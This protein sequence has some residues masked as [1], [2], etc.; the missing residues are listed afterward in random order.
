MLLLKGYYNISSVLFQETNEI[1]R[2]FRRLLSLKY[3][4][5]DDNLKDVCQF[6]I[7]AYSRVG[8]YRVI[9]DIWEEYSHSKA[10]NTKCVKF[11]EH[12]AIYIEIGEYAKAE[13]YLQR[14][15]QFA[16]RRVDKC[17]ARMSKLKVSNIWDK[18]K[19][20]MKND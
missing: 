7:T 6:L 5:K 17:R 19:F 12:I 16:I 4:K 1:Y 9:V 13:K 2:L 11:L 15:T 10:F 8:K 20:D 3:L 14:S 18:F